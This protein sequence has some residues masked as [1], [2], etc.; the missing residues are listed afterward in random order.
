MFIERI[1]SRRAWT[2]AVLVRLYRRWVAAR[3]AGVGTGGSL[4]GLA[5]DLGVEPLAAVALD[6]MLQLTEACLGRR[7]RAECCCS[8]NRCADERALLLL[9]AAAQ[10]ARPGF[11]PATMPHGLPAA[12]AWAAVSL[13]R[14]LDDPLPP[15]VGPI[16]QCPFAA[17]G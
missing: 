10:D 15:A 17:G 1:E 7:L 3:E 5:S 12:L 16:R 2:E 6:S 9:I 4:A 8:A 14:L 11:A 13:N